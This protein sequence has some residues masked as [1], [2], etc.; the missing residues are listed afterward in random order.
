M[1]PVRFPLG[2]ISLMAMQSAWALDLKLPPLLA[3]PAAV[4]K[5]EAFAEGEDGDTWHFLEWWEAHY[6]HVAGFGSQHQPI[7][8]SRIP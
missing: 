4:F 8:A 6:A 3:D 2:I 5:A 1:S 7:P